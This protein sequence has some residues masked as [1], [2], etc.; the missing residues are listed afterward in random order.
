MQYGKPIEYTSRSL[1]P[2]QRRWAQIE[3]ELLL[4]VFG[5]ERFDQY[6]YGRKVAIQN[7]HL[8]AGHNSGKKTLSQA[9]KR[10]QLLMLRV[11]RYDV[12]FQYIQGSRLEV[13]DT[14]SRAYLDVPECQVRSVKTNALKDIPDRVTLA[15]AQATANDPDLQKVLDLINDGWPEEKHLVTPEATPYFDILSHHDGVI[16]KG[17]RV[18]IPTAMRHEMKHKLHAACAYRIR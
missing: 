17:Q 5:L 4:V 12:E 15:V 13:A 1:T 2:T 9:P 18:V 6:T 14:L 3:K 10:L 16:H 7:D 8:P 11:H